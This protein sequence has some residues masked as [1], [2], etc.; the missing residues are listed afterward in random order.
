PPSAAGPDELPPTVD[1]R[2][3]SLF[4]AAWTLAGIARFA[5]G[6]AASLTCFET[7]GW[8]GVMETRTGS[9][10]P[11]RFPS[12]PRA[13]FPVYHVF[14]DLAEHAGAA[15]AP[16]RSSDP[17]AVAGL[18]LY[19]PPGSRRRTLLLA[20]LTSGRVEV[21]ARGLSGKVLLR[22]LDE[23]TAIEAMTAPLGF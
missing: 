5:E 11:A 23:T 16:V 12:I 22:T 3:M 17:Q 21:E 13:V 4:G 20:N 14:A 18:F 19:G 9:P 8:R 10:L 1:P 2:Q 6:G 7:T 15:C